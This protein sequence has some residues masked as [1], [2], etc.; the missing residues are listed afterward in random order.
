MGLPLRRAAV[1]ASVAGFT[2]SRASGSYPSTDSP[3]GRRVAPKQ[4]EAD[5]GSRHH[6]LLVYAHSHTL[7][8][9]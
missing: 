7:S 9:S 4:I 5:W 3:K 2:S 8:S 1:L 6:L